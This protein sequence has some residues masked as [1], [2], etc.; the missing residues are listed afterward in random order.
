MR[1]FPP[2]HVAIVVCLVPEHHLLL[3]QGVS[4]EWL[5]VMTGEEI[6][7]TTPGNMDY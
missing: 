7:I 4:A 6:T 2:S 5:L 1:V 3:S